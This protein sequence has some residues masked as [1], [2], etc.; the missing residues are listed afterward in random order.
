MHGNVLP[1]AGLLHVF[2]LWDV[3]VVGF[4]LTGAVADVPERLKN[5]P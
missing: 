4:K 1:E 2:V 5:R 3:V